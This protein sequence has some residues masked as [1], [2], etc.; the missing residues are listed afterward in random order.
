MSGVNVMVG[1]TPVF[2]ALLKVVTTVRVLLA[3]FTTAVA[4]GVPVGAKV[5]ITKE[6]LVAGAAALPPGSCAPETVAVMPLSVTPEA[7]V[8]VAVNV[9]LPLDHNVDVCVKSETSLLNVT[10]G[11]IPVFIALLKVVATAMVFE[12]T[13]IVTGEAVTDA[14]KGVEVAMFEGV[15]VPTLFWA[16][17]SKS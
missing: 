17:I 3:T 13:V 4:T 9:V 1:A 16:M 11:V 15:E 7:T 14:V 12:A 10:V 5:S 6:L 2:I 8:Y